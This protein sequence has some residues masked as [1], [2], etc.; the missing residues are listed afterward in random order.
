M[1]TM[2]LMDVIFGGRG[3]ALGKSKKREGE[4]TGVNGIGM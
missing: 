4:N 3:V 1:Q 2:R